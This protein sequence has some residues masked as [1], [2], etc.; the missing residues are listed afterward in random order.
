MFNFCN[1]PAGV[2]PITKVRKEE[3]VFV[4]KFTDRMSTCFKKIMEGSEGL[5][6]GIQVVANCWEDEKVVCVMRE[7]EK[8]VKEDF[9]SPFQKHLEKLRDSKKK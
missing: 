3:Q 4:T 5:P 2:L 6:I 1:F 9:R 8:G 7:I